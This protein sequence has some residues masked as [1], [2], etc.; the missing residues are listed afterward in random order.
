[1]SHGDGLSGSRHHE[2]YA[3]AWSAFFRSHISYGVRP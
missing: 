3:P 2:T 1:M